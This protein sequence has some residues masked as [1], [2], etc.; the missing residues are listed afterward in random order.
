[1][2]AWRFALERVC[3]LG[4]RFQ[5]LL[6]LDVRGELCNFFHETLLI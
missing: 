5:F 4:H 1:M 2:L 6:Q 3:C